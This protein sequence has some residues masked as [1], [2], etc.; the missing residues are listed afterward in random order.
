MGGLTKYINVLEKEKLVARSKDIQEEENLNMT[1]VFNSENQAAATAEVKSPEG[2]LKIKRKASFDAENN[3]L[4]KEE[5]EKKKGH[6]EVARKEKN[7]HKIVFFDNDD[8]EEDESE[9]EKHHKQVRTRNICST[10]KVSLDDDTIE[11]EYE[12]E[13]EEK[14]PEPPRRSPRTKGKK[15]LD[16]YSDKYSMIK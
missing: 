12:E 4:E 9:K 10:K 2:A 1:E 6:M 16:Y 5:R 14:S 3:N 8:E 15:K 13:E 7:K 11:E